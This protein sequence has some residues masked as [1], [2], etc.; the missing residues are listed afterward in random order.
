MAW[1]IPKNTTIAIPWLGLVLRMSAARKMKRLRVR[2]KSLGLPGSYAGADTLSKALGGQSVKEALM[3]EDSY[4]LHKPVLYR[5]PCR[6]TIV[7]GAMDQFQCDL[8]DCS[9]YKNHN[10]RIRYLFCCMDVFTK[11]AWVHPLRSKCG[12]ETAQAM[13]SILKAL[14]RMPLSLQSDKGTEMKAAP[15]QNVLKKYKIHF[16]TTENA[17]TKAAVVERFKK[18]L[19]TMIHRYM[20]TT[21]SRRFVDASTL[22]NENLW[23]HLS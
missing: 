2:Y 8:V 20:T 5:F 9:V 7:S 17:T 4:T 22:A 19:Q 21:R 1:N 16:F 3:G 6:K 14:P 23:Y 18:T 10:D 11:Q 12:Q 13:E 15:F